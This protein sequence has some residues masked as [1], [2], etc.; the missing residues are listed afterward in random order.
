[1]SQ[2][3][4]ALGEA[5]LEE[6]PLADRD[7]GGIG[8]L[9]WLLDGRIVGDGRGDGQVVPTERTAVTRDQDSGDV[10]ERARVWHVSVLQQ[11]VRDRP[12]LAAYPEGWGAG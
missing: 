6:E 4:E 12:L 11:C 10:P 3:E 8:L 9:F 5:R 7:P 1:L 2:G